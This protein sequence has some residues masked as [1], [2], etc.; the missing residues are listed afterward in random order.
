MT[1]D[2]VLRRSNGYFIYSTVEGVSFQPRSVPTEP[3]SFCLVR[4]L[5]TAATQPQAGKAD[6]AR[7]Q[8][9]HE[10]IQGLEELVEGMQSGGKRRAIVPPE[11][12]YVQPNTDQPQ[13]PTFSAKRQV[14]NH[15]REPLLFE[16]QLLRVRPEACR[17]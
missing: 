5:C 11:A 4:P 13:L 14:L 3:L 10:V 8:G 17:P 9:K 1:V 12:G 6:C 2:Y 16:V 7:A 15:Y